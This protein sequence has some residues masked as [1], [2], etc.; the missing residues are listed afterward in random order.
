[1]KT[2]SYL[3]KTYKVHQLPVGTDGAKLPFILIEGKQANGNITVALARI[4]ANGDIV[5]FLY[6]TTN[7]QSAMPPRTSFFNPDAAEYLKPLQ[8]AG[9]L[10]PWD[11][12]GSTT[13]WRWET[14]QFYPEVKTV[15]SDPGPEEVLSGALAALKDLKDQR[16][17]WPFASPAPCSTET[18]LIESIDKAISGLEMAV[19]LD[20]A[21]FR[22]GSD[23]CSAPRIQ[24]KQLA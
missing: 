19:L 3:G 14:D 18:K 5:P 6:L 20:A 16:K 12:W 9:I 15:G 1:M 17:Y 10:K 21:L 2:I 24:I 7:T 8:D 11:E 23:R 4:A 13:V 22:R